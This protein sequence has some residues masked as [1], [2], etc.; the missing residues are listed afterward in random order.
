[1]FCLFQQ[2]PIRKWIGSWFCIIFKLNTP[3]W[4]DQISVEC[5]LVHCKSY[6]L[7]EPVGISDGRIANSSFSASSHYASYPPWRARLNSGDSNAWYGQPWDLNPW[8]QV[9][10]DTWIR[11]KW[12]QRFKT[13]QDT[14]K[15][16][17]VLTTRQ[18]FLP[19]PR[20]PHQISPIYIS[21]DCYTGQLSKAC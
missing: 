8:I 4:S 20:A 1:M 7:G 17:R 3:Y 21:S 13:L 5:Y 10:L 2:T 19:R 9:C 12:L 6:G 18:Y 11:I 14:A 16:R 15:G